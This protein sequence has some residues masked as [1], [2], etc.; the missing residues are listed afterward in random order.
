MLQKLK[1]FFKRED[2]SEVL[3]SALYALVTIV[4]KHKI[5]AQLKQDEIKQIG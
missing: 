4:T 5:V 2:V 1:A 3:L